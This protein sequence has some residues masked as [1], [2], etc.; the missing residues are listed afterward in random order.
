MAMANEIAQE[1]DNEEE[2]PPSEASDSKSKD[3]NYI[4]CPAP[5]HLPILCLFEKHH[6]LHSLQLTT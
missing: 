4:F 2:T 6:A 5:H 3:A 1:P